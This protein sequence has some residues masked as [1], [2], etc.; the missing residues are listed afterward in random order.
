MPP[1]TST[2]VSAIASSP[3]STLS[4]AISKALPRVAKFG[5]TREKTTHS[6]ASTTSTAHSPFGNTLE[7]QPRRVTAP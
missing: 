2:G 3:S 6:T 5:A 4:R 1:A 7:R